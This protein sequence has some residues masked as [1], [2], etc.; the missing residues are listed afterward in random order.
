MGKQINYWMEYDSFL[1]VAK[2]ALYAVG[3]RKP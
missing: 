3:I 2:K 1:L